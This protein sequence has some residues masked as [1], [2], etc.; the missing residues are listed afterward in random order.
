MKDENF[1]FIGIGRDKIVSDKKELD[2]YQEEI[3]TDEE[4][5]QRDYYMIS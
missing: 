5:K 4:W 3:T 2:T 1:E